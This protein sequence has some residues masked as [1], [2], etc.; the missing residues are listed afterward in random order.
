MGTITSSKTLSHS[1]KK[2]FKIYHEDLISGQ[3]KATLDIRSKLY[4]EFTTDGPMYA[5]NSSTV[6]IT[7][8]RYAPANLVD[9]ETLDESE[10]KEPTFSIPKDNVEVEDLSNG[11]VDI[12]VVKIMKDD[13]KLVAQE[14]NKCNSTQN[15][16]SQGFVSSGSYIGIKVKGDENIFAVILRI[17][18]DKSINTFDSLTQ[19]FEWDEAIQ[20]GNNT[21]F[22][23]LEDYANLYNKDIDMVKIDEGI[24]ETKYLIPYM[25][26]QTLHSWNSLRDSGYSAFDINKN[27]LFSRI[28][29][30]YILEFDVYRQIEEETEN[31]LNIYT[32]KETVQEYLDVFESW[33]NLYNRNLNPYILNPQ[34]QEVEYEIWKKI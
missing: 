18:G 17:K 21:L 30:P 6:S 27:L 15:V 31:G 26:K 33:T 11:S 32:E 13:D 12:E 5:K 28:Q 19:R 1:G 20:L 10:Y 22:S 23:N 14:L 25:A 4:T 7:V 34:K 3:S 29:I 24:Y 9:R 2:K 8:S 16:S